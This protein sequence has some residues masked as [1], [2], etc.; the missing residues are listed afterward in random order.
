VAYGIERRAKG[1]L[2][3]FV[4]V[5]P[6]H[7]EDLAR[8]QPAGSGFRQII[9]AH[10]PQDWR[11]V[12]ESIWY[13]VVPP[14]ASVPEQ[15]FKIHLSAT[16]RTAADLLGRAVP[17]FVGAGAA[18]KVLVD[19]FMLDFSNSKNYSRASSGKFIT[20]YPADTEVCG[21][22]L[23]SLYLATKDL[24][25]PHVL[26]DRPYKD[27]KVVFYRYGGFRPQYRINLFGERVPVISDR[28]GELVPDERSPFFHLPPEVVDPFSNGQEDHQGTV[29]LKD[30]YAVYGVL[31]FSNSGGVYTAEDRETAKKVVV[32]EARPFVNL[33]ENGSADAVALLQKE[34]RV[35]Q[36]LQHTPLV[37]R[38]VD[39]FQEWDHHFLVEEH[40]EG[41]LLSS[42]RALEDVGLL[43]QRTIT[44]ERVADFCR[45][46]GRLAVA[47]IDA[48]REF[49]RHGVILGDL[50]PSNVFVD[51]ATLGIKLID[52]EGAFLDGEEGSILDATVTTGFVHERRLSG[53]RPT[54]ADDFFSLGSV[55]YSVILPVQEMFP[56]HPQGNLRFLEA[57]ARDFD[58]PPEIGV[59]VSALLEDE[60][61]RARAAAEKLAAPAA[62]KRRW[63]VRF[64]APP[65]ATPAEIRRTVEGVRDYILAT[66]EPDRK[67]RL[68][69]A[70]YRIFATNPLNVAYGA[71][72][73]CLFLRESGV[74]LPAEVRDWIAARPIDEES[75][76]P[77]LY[78]GLAGLAWALDLL[79]FPDR[80]AQ[81]ID[82]AYRSPLVHEGPDVFFGAAGLGLASLYF[83]GRTGDP[84]HLDHARQAAAALA[85]AA[86]TD[87]DGP[88]WI[89]A[90][91]GRYY[92]Y[93]HG[94][95]G[96]AY[97]FLR[98][99]QATGDP[100]LLQAARDALEAE[101]ARAIHQDDYVV[102]ERS[103]NDTLRSPYW[104]YGAAGV[105][106]VLIRFAVALG[107]ERYR[108]LAVKAARYVSA[109]Y[110]VLP[111]QFV[112]L[113]G[114][115]EF[116]LDMY[117]LTGDGSHLD[118]AWRLA[119][120][121]LLFSVPRP[122][123]VAFPGE[124]LIRLSTDFGTG[125]AGIGMFLLRL[126]NPGARIFY[127]FDLP[128]E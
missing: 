9:E 31:R 72:G 107:E 46:F 71:L 75:Y 104:R 34:A 100:A 47:L 118:D 32:K 114:M 121:I 38:Y 83:W 50:A 67:D 111:S 103:A 63:K 117:H 36:R 92:G 21:A 29:V 20:I 53:E 91:G 1:D 124:E 41:V 86:K 73:T 18:F 97:F 57:I 115:G 35:L 116:L 42:Y 59:L 125:S 6:D 120:T 58:L 23:E 96:I 70:D 13:N 10:L 16:S 25:G 108:D 69:P 89:N 122:A 55:L 66:T 88:H 80:A 78:V 26:S 39:S 56:L 12:R 99:H 119:E 90:D 22:L 110:V 48:V 4:L 15:G 128:R 109:K 98:L 2:F 7:Y 44:A 87:E 106:S 14:D 127:E 76:P 24:A 123:G 113:S 8:Y 28:N 54:C 74:E 93:A 64:D 3:N 95:S 84:R 43:V 40:V 17:L 68:W 94:G 101:I 19:S 77:G 27:S 33:T 112:G 49:H 65:E 81:A 61:D 52:F 51:P 126:L 30:R 5:S 45:R 37:P 11:L 79:G 85:A 105:G 60:V 102:W 82:L 62:R